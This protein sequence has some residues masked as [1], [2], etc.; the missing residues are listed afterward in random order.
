MIYSSYCRMNDSIPY[1]KWAFLIGIIFSWFPWDP[2]KMFFFLEKSNPKNLPFLV[3]FS[4][5]CVLINSQIQI[6][7]PRK[8][9]SLNLKMMVWKMIFLFQRRILRFHVNLPG[10]NCTTTAQIPGNS[11]FSAP[12]LGCWVSENVTLSKGLNLVKSNWGIFQ[13]V[14]DWITWQFVEIHRFMWDLNWDYFHMVGDGK[15]NPTIGVIYPL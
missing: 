5:I 3:S 12:F 7:T 9:N 4:S 8:I 11:A 6:F 14:T 2:W 10:C 15:L 1:G 13:R